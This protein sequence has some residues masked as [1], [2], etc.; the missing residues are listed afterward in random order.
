MTFWKFFFQVI[1]N[2]SLLVFL[3]FC[4]LGGLVALYLLDRLVDACFLQQDL[5]DF[6]PRDLER[7]E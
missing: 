4:L 3:T 1:K 5:L 7:F 6:E 2:I